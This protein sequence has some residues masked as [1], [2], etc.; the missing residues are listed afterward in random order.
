M[1]WLTGRAW[2]QNPGEATEAASVNFALQAG[3]IF[4]SRLFRVRSNAETVN[5]IT[6]VIQPDVGVQL[7]GLAMFRLG[8]RW[9]VHGG[10]TL[11]I[12][13]YQ[14]SADNGEERL[15]LHLNTTLYELPLQIAYY[16]PL[17]QRAYLTLGTGVLFQSLPSNLRVR[18]PRLDVFSIKRAFAMPASLTT[19]GLEIRRKSKGGY[20]MGIS[21]CIT[22]F[23][24]YDTSFKAT[25][26][27]ADN[28]HNL[29]HIGDYFGVV[30]RYYLD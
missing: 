7:G 22:P 21:Y 28:F 4:P 6:Y 24:L 27:S 2:A 12:R 11:L 10:L 17:A 1:A 26:N 29:A 23:P 25:F 3:P 30:L 20:F 5:G 19:A 8:N 18:D 13:G 16:Q 9:Q 15:G 14:V